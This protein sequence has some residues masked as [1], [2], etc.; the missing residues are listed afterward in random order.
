MEQINSLLCADN[1][2]I[3]SR[4]KTGLQ[5]CNHILFVL[6]NMD[7]KNQPEEDKNNDIPKRPR[8]SVDNNFA[9]SHFLAELQIQHSP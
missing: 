3:L 7:V 8:K 1:L 4:S 9:T 2:I 6:R 5:N